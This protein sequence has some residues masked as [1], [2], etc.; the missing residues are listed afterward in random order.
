M[1]R[2]K[3]HSK[4]MV[5]QTYYQE[6]TLDSCPWRRSTGACPWKSFLFAS[7][8][9]WF[10]PARTCLTFL[11]APL[12]TRTDHSPVNWSNTGN[13]EDTELVSFLSGRCSYPLSYQNIISCC[14]LNL[15]WRPFHKW[16]EQNSLSFSQACWRTGQRTWQIT[17]YKLCALG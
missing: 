10:R 11:I 1:T 8:T 4:K 17:P 15:F 5:T 6:L 9:C 3:V 12:W 14:F 2:Y 16:N 7:R 13:W